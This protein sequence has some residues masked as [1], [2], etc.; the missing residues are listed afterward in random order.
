MLIT[1]K[2]LENLLI[3]LAPDGAD[4]IALLTDIVWCGCNPD[5]NRMAIGCRND[6]K[7]WIYDFSLQFRDRNTQPASDV[8]DPEKQSSL[9]RRLSHFAAGVARVTGDLW[10][11]SRC[12]TFLSRLPKISR[13]PI[14]SFHSDFSF[15]SRFTRSLERALVRISCL[16]D[17]LSSWHHPHDIVLDIMWWAWVAATR[18]RFC[19]MRKQRTTSLD[20]NNRRCDAQFSHNHV[21]TSHTWE[22]RKKFLQKN[23]KNTSERNH[24]K[25]SSA[26]KM[27]FA[28][29]MSRKRREQKS[30][31]IFL[32]AAIVFARNSQSHCV[33]RDSIEIEIETL[34]CQNV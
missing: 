6:F 33:T 19:Q 3:Q 34:Q 18:N 10:A 11:K 5:F 21:Q 14:F 27:F 13:K 30:S 26:E 22:K 23:A 4:L 2:F 29:K 8:T 15:N 1:C 25:I 28:A 31:K 17:R 20:D 7:C 9:P 32:L 24:I 12:S 16:P